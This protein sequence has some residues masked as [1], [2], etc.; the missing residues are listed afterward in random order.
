MKRVCVMGT[1]YVGLVTGSCLADFGN[2]V[3]CV[4]IDQQR[5]GKLK[6]GESPIYEPGLDELIARNVDQG[7]LT[8]SSEV[9]FAI[10][11]SEIIF[12][13]V[14]TP[15][16]PTGDVDMSFVTGA[17]KMI[18]EF[19]EDHKIIVNKS[20]VPVGTGVDVSEV[21]RKE[22]PDQDF[23]VVSNPEFLREGSAIDDFLHPDRLVIGAT[24]KRAMEAILDVYNP[25]FEHDVPMVLTDVESAEMI[26]YASNALLAAKI[27]FINEIAN[28]CEAYGADVSAVARGMGF[29]ERIGYRNLNAGAGYGG[30]CF[31]KDVIGLVAT[32]RKGGVDAPVIEAI[33]PSNSSQRQ[34]MISKL[35][36]LV[37]PFSGKS[38]CLL[39]LSFKP[40][41][42]DIRDAPSLEMIEALL[43]AGA[44]VKAYDP[45]AN[46]HAHRQFPDIICCEDPYTAAESCDAIVLMTE[47]NEFRN[48]DLPRL[49]KLLVTPKF[50]DCRNIYEPQRMS[51]I[52]FEY[53]SVGRKSRMPEDAS[54]E[55]DWTSPGRFVPLRR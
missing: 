9:A 42:D 51:E 39:G 1:G 25:L 15:P 8:F 19:M 6:E 45:V 22:K 40:D 10:K 48:I 2:T 17:A 37:G 21:I 4:D 55:L 44:S 11:T 16:M 12:I 38:V 28:I 13:C 14:G 31:P 23:D 32:A 7:R 52:G 34:R 43:A 27:S 30:S 29:D 50:L 36:D 24:S 47:W 49:Q 54:E 20:T 3:V 18:G 33:D 35:A 5:I 41:T 46:D 53:V 26:K